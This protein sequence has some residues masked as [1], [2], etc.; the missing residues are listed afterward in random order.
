MRYVCLL[1]VFVL[2]LAACSSSETQPE[3]SELDDIEFGP[4]EPWYNEDTGWVSSLGI[5]G[6]THWVNERLYSFVGVN[7]QGYK[8]YLRLRD[9]MVCVLI[10]CGDFYKRAYADTPPDNRVEGEFLNFDD[11]LYDKYEVTNTQVAEFLNKLE[12]SVVDNILIAPD[13]KTPWVSEHK[14]GLS[15]S[16]LI[17]G[18][19][20][21]SDSRT[22]DG[23]DKVYIQ[24]QQGYEKHPFVGGTGFLAEAYAKW[25]GGKLPRGM[26]YEK[27]AAGPSGLLFPWG[28]YGEMPNSNNCNG[29]LTGP[30]HTMPVGSYPKGISPYGLHDMAG[31]VYERA[32]WDDGVP[33]DDTP[34]SQATMLK[35]GSWVSS[36]WWNFRC[37][38]RC[39]QPMDAMEGSVGFRVV[40][41]EDLGALVENAPKLRTFVDTSDAYAEAEERNVPIF[42]YLG[43]ER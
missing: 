18:N 38:C 23:F 11:M 12:F 28:N 26:Q 14:W 16:A 37:V 36:N 30:K 40:V 17:D 43:Y 7:A 32:Y 2:A 31:N 25:V 4:Q 33:V 20:N 10:P 35:G 3:S 19:S 29:Y 9:K 1:S 39:G 5:F 42:L 27:A 41:T 15:F 8:E 24:P 34:A 22:Q 6:E 13:G 21:G